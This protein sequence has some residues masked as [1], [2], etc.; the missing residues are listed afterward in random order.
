MEFQRDTAEGG[1]RKII[2][3][4]ITEDDGMNLEEATRLLDRIVAD[5]C[6]AGLRAP[7]LRSIECEHRILYFDIF[8]MQTW[9]CLGRIYREQDYNVLIRE[10]RALLN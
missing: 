1:Y 2:L 7:Y 6:R 10:A 4:E 9:A 3:R 8:N 5:F